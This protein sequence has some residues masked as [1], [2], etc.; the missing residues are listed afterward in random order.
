M[1]EEHIEH[2][3]ALH[4]HLAGR[5]RYLTGPAAR[6]TLNRHLLSPLALKVADEIGLGETCDNPYRSILVRA[7]DF[8]PAMLLGV[9]VGVYRRL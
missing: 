7:V 2:S 8:K 3:T 5:G 4:A 6:Y 1:I 9:V